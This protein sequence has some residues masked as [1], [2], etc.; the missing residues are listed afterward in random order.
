M[1]L[2]SKYPLENFC[3]V[4]ANCYTHLET[5][6]RYFHKPH[7]ELL[8]ATEICYSVKKPLRYNF[9]NIRCMHV[10]TDICYLCPV[11]THWFGSEVGVGQGIQLVEEL[12]CH[13][14]DLSVSLIFLSLLSCC[15]LYVHLDDLILSLPLLEGVVTFLVAPGDHVLDIDGI[16]GV[17]RRNAVLRFI[18][19]GRR[20]KMVFRL[21][22]GS[23]KLS[24]LFSWSKGRDLE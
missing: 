3:K 4:S 17:K 19:T 13:L 11:W 16:K 6:P 7:P 2:S 5:T 12:A 14:S 24:L 10:C 9:S 15:L 21:G 1:V 22:K 8:L 18:S 23:A 20:D